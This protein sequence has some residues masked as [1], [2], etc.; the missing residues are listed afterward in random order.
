VPFQSLTSQRGDRLIIDDPHSV[1]TAESD[2]ERANT[3][4]RFKE[5][6]LNRLNNQVSSAIVIVMQRLHENDVSG[7]ILAGKMGYVHLMLPM[8]FEND[9]RCTTKIGFT[10]PRTCDGELL[11]PVRFPRAVIDLEF[12]SPD[13]MGSYAYAGQ[14]QQRP[15]AREG[16]LFKRRWFDEKLIDA[17][18]LPEHI[19]WV[20]H[21]DLAATERRAA[22]TKGARTAGVKMGRSR[23]GKYFIAHCVAKAIEGD[24]VRKLIRAT[25]EVDGHNTLVSLPQDPGQAGKVQ[26]ADLTGVLAGFNVR[27]APEKGDKFQRAEPFS[28]QC[29]GGNVYIVRGHWNDE[30]FDELCLFPGGARKDIVDACSGAFGRLIR[31]PHLAF[32]IPAGPIIFTR[33]RPDYGYED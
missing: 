4:R 29:E 32:Q 21:W 8:E 18:E 14:Y 31:Q 17:R 1:N 25:A 16:G 3:T 11:D 6:A 12:K 27:I 33:Q 28:A 13:G 23:N 2:K 5:G 20:R 15:V 7:V 26:R 22:D 19:I 9:R 10:D 24:A 30:L